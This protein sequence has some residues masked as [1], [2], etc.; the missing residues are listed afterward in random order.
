MNPSIHDIELIERYFDNSLNEFEVIQLK[1][2]LGSEPEL[3]SFF[4]QERL[5][6]NTIRF[7]AA[8]NDL[9]FL[10]D[11]ETSLTLSSRSHIRKNWYYYAA[12][13]CITI[14]VAA[15]FFAPSSVQTS[16]D[17]YASYFEPYPNVFE[18]TM[19]GS[20]SLI[21][22]PALNLRAE[23]FQAYEEGNYEKAAGLFS[24][25]LQEKK[26]PGILLLLGNTNLALNK[27]TEA[28]QNFNDLIN[29]FDDLDIQAK[30][31][32]SLCFL[33]EGNTQQARQLLEELG[34][35]EISYAKKAKEL[36]KEVN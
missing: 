25:L 16:Q 10:K 33:K 8:Q 26:E 2:R 36:L 35:T 34:S 22:R 4:D 5:L 12:A 19:R 24:A 7:K 31:F 20:G 18:P 3:K 1:N 14:L 13:A 23:A 27:T 9:R 11:L 17:L 6:I 29:N 30:W 32:L 21:R 28:K 15:G